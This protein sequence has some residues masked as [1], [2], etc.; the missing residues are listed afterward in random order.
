MDFWGFSKD[1]WE[2]SQLWDHSPDPGIRSRPI[3]GLGIW[4][5]GWIWEGKPQNSLEFP[6]FPQNSLNLPRIHQV[7]P[8]FPWNSPIPIPFF[9]PF[10]FCSHPLSI[11]EFLGFPGILGIL[12]SPLCFPAFHVPLSPTEGKNSPF[13]F[14]GLPSFFHRYFSLVFGFN[15]RFFFP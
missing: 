7:F 11:P 14:F 1:F 10:F 2:F 15:S 9:P 12:T 6:K 4:D 5:L 13:F 8:K 3:P